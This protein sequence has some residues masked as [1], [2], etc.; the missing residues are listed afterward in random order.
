M[1]K[2]P[3]VLVL[4]S[5]LCNGQHP[6]QA[7]LQASVEAGIDPYFVE[8]KDTV[9]KRGPWNITR[10]ILT[11]SKGTI[12]LATWH[13]IMSYDGKVFTNHTLKEN[14]IHFHV[15]SI[16]EDKKGILWFGTVRGGLYRYDGKTFKLFTKK[17]GLPD[18][19]IE[20]MT[21]DNVGNM[22]FAT[23]NGLSCYNGK[24]FKNYTTADGLAGNQIRAIMQ[25]RNGILWVGTYEGLTCYDGKTFSLFKTEKGDS[26]KKVISLFEDKSGKIWIGTLEGI[27]SYNGKSLSK[28]LS[29]Y[30][31]NYFVQDKKG[32]IYFTHTEQNIFNPSRGDQCLYKYDGKDFTK[33]LEK[34]EGNDF[35]IFGKSFDKN[36]DLWF[37]TMHGA[38][39]YDEKTFTYFTN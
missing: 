36:G 6:T 5:F 13:G 3:L 15:F 17:D 4:L 34:N 12:W 23:D 28:Y 38:C 11:D 35:Q 22:W 32:N 39:K 25:D 31:T 24:T 29:N 30:L 10:D 27:M 7:Q 26:L 8:S 18:N 2:L 20:C 14:L 9:S 21:E 16:Y 19:M 37:G 33:I 1:K